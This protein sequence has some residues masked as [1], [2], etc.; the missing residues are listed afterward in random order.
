MTCRTTTSGTQAALIAD[1]GGT[2]VRFGLAQADGRIE[3][4]VALLCRDYADP[5]AAAEAYLKQAKPARKPKTGAFG[6]ACVVDGDHIGLTNHHW[7]FSIDE[8]RKRLGLDKLRV[9]ND[10]QALTL[11][12]NHL[13]PGEKA[14]IGGGKPVQGAPVAIVAP[15]T[16]LGASAIVPGESGRT[17]IATEA[18]H[19]TMPVVTEREAR[20]NT[21]LSRKFGHVSTERV[22]SGPGLVNLY[23]AICE[24]DGIAADPDVDPASVSERGGCNACARCAETLKVFSALLG[25]F[26]GDMALTFCAQGGVFLGGGVVPKLGTGFDAGL[27]RQRFEQKGRFTDYLSN[28]PT[29]LITRPNP[30]LVGLAR[31]I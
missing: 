12:V 19:V 23:R 7:S 28:I 1:I 26:A 5:A 10:V 8:T 25:T 11:A 4:V 17:L 13:E 16:G 6:V 3:Q 15:G 29:E 9:L 18:G 21:V 30:A 24:I 22:V 14:K 20:I 27:F 2:N 31:A